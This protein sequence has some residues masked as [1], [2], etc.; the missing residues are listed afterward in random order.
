[1]I[2]NDNFT[3]I[4]SLQDVIDYL[5]NNLNFIEDIE[6]YS[7]ILSCLMNV[8]LDDEDLRGETSTHFDELVNYLRNVTGLDLERTVTLCNHMLNITIDC[9]TRHIAIDHPTYAKDFVLTSEI[10]G[11]N[12]YVHFKKI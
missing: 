1:M 9:V 6:F 10:M 3:I 2:A 12:A 11:V 5:E 7:F 8:I 4:F